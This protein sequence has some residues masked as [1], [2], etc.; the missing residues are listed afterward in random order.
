[1]GDCESNNSVYHKTY[2]EKEWHAVNT[3]L[4][5]CI[6]SSN[7]ITCLAK[8]HVLP[9]SRRDGPQLPARAPGPGVDCSA[10]TILAES[11]VE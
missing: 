8:G 10:V 6:Y 4:K 1:M 11:V 2:T 5:R 9:S 7:S 3:F